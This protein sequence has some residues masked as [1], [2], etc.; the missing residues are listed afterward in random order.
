[1]PE[2]TSSRRRGAIGLGTC[3]HAALPDSGLAGL[4]RWS[5]GRSPSPNLRALARR[6][7]NTKPLL[8]GEASRPAGSPLPEATPRGRGSHPPFRYGLEYPPNEE[9]PGLLP[10]PRLTCMPRRRLAGSGR[11]V[12]SVAAGSSRR[13]RGGESARSGAVSGSAMIAGRLLRS[14]ARTRR[15]RRSCRPR[16]HPRTV[17][18]QETSAQETSAQETSAQETSAQE[19]SAQ[20]TTF[21]AA[22]AQE[23]ESHETESHGDV[24]LGDVE[25]ADCVGRTS[26]P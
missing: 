25:P 12:A 2:P 9:R 6:R 13:P 26:R 16:R 11:A 18:A 3:A 10:A 21:Q 15:G 7:R 17:S 22:S 14:A 8:R 24:R 5:S 1:M 19:T 23:T 4:E 20:E